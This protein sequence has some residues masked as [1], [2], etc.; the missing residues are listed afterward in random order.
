MDDKQTKVILNCKNES[1]RN[2]LIF[3]LECEFG[4]DVLSFE[5]IQDAKDFVMG[6]ILNDSGKTLNISMFVSVSTKVEDHSSINDIIDTLKGNSIVV[7]A[8][9]LCCPEENA[10]IWE[11]SISYDLYRH[12]LIQKEQFVEDFQGLINEF[13]TVNSKENEE[14]TSISIGPLEQFSGLKEDIFIMLR[15]GRL[16]KLYSEGDS[17]GRD[18]IDRLEKKGVTHLYLKK[19][20]C[21]WILKTL[22]DNFEK[23]FEDNLQD[24]SLEAPNLAEDFDSVVESEGEFPVEEFDSSKPFQIE[25]KHVEMIHEKRKEVV[26]KLKNIKSLGK[27]LKNMKIDREEAAFLATRSELVCNICTAVA[28]EME[29]ASEAAIEKFVYI[30]HLH[31]ILLVNHPRLFKIGDTIEIETRDDLS[32]EDKQIIKDHPTAAAD[33]VKHDSKIPADVDAIISQHH[34]RPA[35]SGFPRGI[36]AA[37]VLPFAALTQIAIDFA[38]FIIENPNWTFA[39][40]SKLR[41]SYFTGGS[42]TKIFA[43]LSRVIDKN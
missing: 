25:R 6:E 34:E 23:I 33:F 35:G 39:R 15:T 3:S 32:D 18:D 5:D 16:L 17:I 37:R 12:K 27:L 13:F 28:K 30:A 19:S 9:E 14:H 10:D 41:K 11:T 38:Q 31:D 22:S 24:I 4:F 20:R 8:I 42:F 2:Y 29:W 36:G 40:Y 7:P 21:Q 43:A 1:L 26:K